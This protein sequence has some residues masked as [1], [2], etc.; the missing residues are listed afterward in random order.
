MATTPNIAAYRAKERELRAAVR[1]WN[2][3]LVALLATEL[4]GWDFNA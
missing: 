1:D 4:D 2:W 3:S